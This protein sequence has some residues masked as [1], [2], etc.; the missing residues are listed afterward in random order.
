[1]NVA[2]QLENGVLLTNEGD[3][4]TV[5]LDGKDCIL[6]IVEQYLVDLEPP[7]DGTTCE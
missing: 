5:V 7:E 2:E 6:D 3:G 1:M 4:H